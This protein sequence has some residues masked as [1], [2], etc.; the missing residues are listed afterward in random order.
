MQKTFS[1]RRKEFDLTNNYILDLTNN[2]ILE[3]LIFHGKSC[4]PGFT[5]FREK[6]NFRNRQNREIFFDHF[7]SSSFPTVPCGNWWKVIPFS[8]SLSCCFSFHDE[9]SQFGAAQ[10]GILFF[11]ITSNFEAFLAKWSQTLFFSLL[12]SVYF[13][14]EKSFQ[15]PVVQF[16]MK[17]KHF[18]SPRTE[19]V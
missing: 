11:T 8:P 9:L 3:Q 5:T 18:V 4:A 14:S 17:S 15:I 13:R 1:E 16:H 10:Y 6:S 2:Y 19:W 7:V 12:Y